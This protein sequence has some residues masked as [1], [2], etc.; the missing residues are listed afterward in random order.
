MV[1]LQPEF[2]ETKYNGHIYRNGIPIFGKIVVL[3]I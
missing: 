3:Y 2:M 1:A